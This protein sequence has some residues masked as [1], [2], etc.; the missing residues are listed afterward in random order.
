MSHLPQSRCPGEE[1]NPGRKFTAPRTWSTL[2]CAQRAQL[3]DK[4]LTCLLAAAGYDDAG[5]LF[6]EGEGGG[7]ADAREAAGDQ[8][9]ESSD[10]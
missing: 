1:S 7:A 10:L 4:G 3:S 2:L 5:V 6:G 8:D 9:N